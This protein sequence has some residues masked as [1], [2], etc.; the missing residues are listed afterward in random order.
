MPRIGTYSTGKQQM[1][2]ECP[3]GKH[4]PV[5]TL[6]TVNDCP[7]GHYSFGAAGSCF[8]CP[9]GYQ[10]PN[11]DGSGNSRCIHVSNAIFSLWKY[12]QVLFC[13]VNVVVDGR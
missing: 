5:T 7:T 11:K 10:C 6:A 13:A 12:C 1:C 9:K 4:C 3:P 2:T 8:P